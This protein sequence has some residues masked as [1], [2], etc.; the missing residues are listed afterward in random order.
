MN[1]IRKAKILARKRS[2]DAY[3][4]SVELAIASY[5]LDTGTFSTDLHNPTVEYSGQTVVCNVM[6]MKEN[7]GLY[8][9]ECTVNNIDVKDSSTDDG[10]YHYNTRDLEDYEYVDMYAKSLEKALKEY[11]DTNNSYPN[12]YQT[13]TLDYTGKK[14]NCDVIV[15]PDGTVYLTKCNVNDIEVLDETTDD[16]YYHYGKILRGTDVLLKKVNGSSVT[17]YTDGNT[18]EMYTLTHPATTQQNYE[19]TDYRYIGVNP[20]NYVPFNNELWRII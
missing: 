11:H 6:S 9:S 10:W 17:N 15:N 14:I 13:L 18:S 5:L 1:I 16:G 2:V 20:N 19:V 8:M 4:R 12:D 7:G 3:G